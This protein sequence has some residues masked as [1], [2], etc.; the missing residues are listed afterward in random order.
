[1]SACG[2]MP[3]RVD[4]M[5]V[6]GALATSFF[7]FAF[8]PPAQDGAANRTQVTAY[9]DSQAGKHTDQGFISDSSVPDF[10]QPL[11]LQDA[12][13]WPITL[14]RGV[15][16]RVFAVCDNGCSDVDLDLYDHAGVFV[17][18]DVQTNDKPYVE[19]TPRQD[20]VHFA[21]IWLA[22]CEAEPCY[23]GGRVYRSRTP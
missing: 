7:L 12:V 4:L 16:Y 21:R 3:V 1:M 20:G 10:V 8:A 5:R 9:L 19:I 13:V 11:T 6:A 23:V 15:T 18:R 2:A 17:G 14:R 22:T